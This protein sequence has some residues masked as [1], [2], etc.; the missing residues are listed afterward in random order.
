MW[1]GIIDSRQIYYNMITAFCQ[2]MIISGGQ[3]PHFDHHSGQTC[4]FKNLLYAVQDEI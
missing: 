1:I 3:C 2:Q 4:F